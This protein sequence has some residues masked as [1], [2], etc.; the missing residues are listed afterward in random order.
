MDKA[1]SLRWGGHPQQWGGTRLVEMIDGRERGVRAVE[2]RTG[3][4]LEFDVLVDRGMDVGAARYKGSS[5]VWHSQAGF[6]APAFREHQDI[7]WMRMFGG[8]LFMTA[9]LD[10]IFL[11]E[12]D[13][14]D[15]YEY[16]SRG[17]AGGMGYD[18]HGRIGTTPGLLRSYGETWDGDVC[19]LHAEGEVR[20]GGALAESLVLRRRIESTLDGKTIAWTDDVEN[21]GPHTTPHMMLYHINFGAPLLG[22]ECELVL[23]SRGIR[24]MTPNV[25]GR[26]ERANRFSGP[27]ADGVEEVFE[28]DMAA[29]ANGDVEVALINRADPGAPWGITLTYP[30]EKFPYF[31]QWHFLAEGSYALGFEPTTNPP[32]NRTMARE[33][34]QMVFLEPG[35]RVVSRC[36]VT[37]VDGTAEVDAATARI[38]AVDLG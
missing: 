19:T 17:A 7:G 30:R 5:L 24:W 18:L 12:H 20:Q 26:P 10:H 34:G 1:E 21:E 37:V 9:G 14:N 25:E 15:T 16:P 6:A 28:H 35:E 8:G 22:P 33:A 3:A 32:G 36:A 38:R 31:L 11:G 13:P 27:E 4:G 2:F 23:P 29:D